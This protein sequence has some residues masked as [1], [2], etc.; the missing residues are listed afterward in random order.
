MAY[1]TQWIFNQFRANA[2]ISSNASQYSGA[3]AAEY[4]RVVE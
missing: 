3:I 4:Q 2:P 1:F